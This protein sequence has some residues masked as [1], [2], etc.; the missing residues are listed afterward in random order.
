MEE[1]NFITV[2]DY[3]G[4]INKGIAVLLSMRI[5]DNIY[6]IGYWFDRDDNYLISADENFLKD[7]NIK[8]I[9]EY[10]N[11]SKLAFYIH[12]YVLENKEELY[13]EFLEDDE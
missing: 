5:I 2:I 13:K 4:G 6:Q 3:I 10:K 1:T 12:N 9:Y 8:D 7:F 11:C